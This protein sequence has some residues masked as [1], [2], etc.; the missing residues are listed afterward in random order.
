ML[1][2]T[3]LLFP[4]RHVLKVEGPQAFFKGLLPTLVGSIPTRAIYFS[5]YTQFKKYF[6]QN[7]SSNSSWVHLQAAISAGVLTSTCTS[8]IWVIKTQMQL[9]NRSVQHLLMPLFH[10]SLH[11]PLFDKTRTLM[12]TR[13]CFPFILFGFLIHTIAVCHALIF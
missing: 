11:N 3:M 5:S 2:L 9:D 1:S 7:Q 13:Q 8:P 12:Q 6:G 4:S 10:N